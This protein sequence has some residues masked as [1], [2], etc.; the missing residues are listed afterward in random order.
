MQRESGRN[1]QRGHPTGG[2]RSVSSP[3]G[4]V[5]AGRRCPCG[6]LAGGDLARRRRAVWAES[7]VGR[8]SAGSAAVEPLV[9][10]RF[11]R[12]D[13]VPPPAI[14][15][16]LVASDCSLAVGS[17]L[18]A[19][20]DASRRPKRP[21]PAQCEALRLAWTWLLLIPWCGGSHG[22]RR[23]GLSD[24]HRS[25]MPQRAADVSGTRPTISTATSALARAHGRRRL[26]VLLAL[27]PAVHVQQVVERQSA[28][29][30]DAA[31]NQQYLRAWQTQP[32]VGGP[33][34]RHDCR[35]ADRGVVDDLR[36]TVHRLLA[37][38]RDTVAAPSHATS[39]NCLA[40]VNCT[41]SAAL[42][43]SSR[44]C[45]RSR[46]IHGRNSGWPSSDEARRRLRGGRRTLRADHRIAKSAGAPG[47]RTAEACCG[48][49]TSDA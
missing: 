32:G 47:C 18:V 8:P 36:A 10:P 48:V 20:L 12:L 49:P 19:E 17:L 9:R 15:V 22:L 3:V 27:L 13:R 33:W 1:R 29:V 37:K 31:I 35:S 45:R 40:P 2:R 24:T 28:L 46:T 42:T 16:G 6:V 26:A 21:R 5:V 41:A 23:R 4:L 43:K 30:S 14:G 44:S 34:H 11:G 25:R 7:R 38:C 39:R